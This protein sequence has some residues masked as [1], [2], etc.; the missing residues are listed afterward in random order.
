MRISDKLRSLNLAAIL[1]FLWENLKTGHCN[2]VQT[3][4]QNAQGGNVFEEC[5]D[6]LPSFSNSYAPIN[7][8]PQ[9]GGRGADT[10]EFDIFKEARV[11]FPTPRH[12]LNFKFPPLG[13]FRRSPY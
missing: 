11:Q 8:K 7:V 1:G 9:G 10:G 5:Q 4:T 13:T 2:C 12:L 6:H 3:C